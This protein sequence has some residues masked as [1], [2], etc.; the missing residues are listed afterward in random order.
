MKRQASILNQPVGLE[1]SRQ[2]ILSHCT[3]KKY[4]FGNTAR[5]TVF[6]TQHARKSLEGTTDDMIYFFREILGVA[7]SGCGALKLAWP[8]AY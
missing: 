5:Q 1:R 6:A 3:I 7:C 8:R 2:V 4:I